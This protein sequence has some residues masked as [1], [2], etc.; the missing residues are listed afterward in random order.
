MNKKIES[1]VVETTYFSGGN[2]VRL[3]ISIIGLLVLLLGGIM[4]ASIILIILG[5]FVCLT[6][7]AMA[8]IAAPK[9]KIKFT[10]CDTVDKSRTISKSMD[11]EGCGQKF[12]IKWNNPE[13][14]KNSIAAL[15]KKK[16]K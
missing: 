13:P 7:A 15:F 12:P 6:G 9:V 14:K 1:I 4:M 10:A 8:V 2:P 3:V 5:I 11:C 16:R